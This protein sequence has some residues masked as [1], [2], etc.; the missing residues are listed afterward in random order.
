VRNLMWNDT[1]RY[2]RLF[3]DALMTGNRAGQTYFYHP[4]L[5]VNKS[6][7]GAWITYEKQAVAAHSCI[8]DRVNYSLEREGRTERIRNIPTSGALVALVERAINQGIPGM[9]TGTTAERLNQIFV[10]N[11]HP[12]DFAWYY[13]SLVSYASIY[14]RSPAELPYRPDSI[15]AAAM[16][17]LR[18][19]AWD[20]VRQYETG[21]VAKTPAQCADLMV[22]SFCAAFRTVTG[23]DPSGCRARF[24][25]TS[26]D[27]PFYY[28]AASDRSY[29][30][31]P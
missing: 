14:H 26:T 10:D 4:W 1:V 3:H 16:P 6:A 20:Y 18:T 19:L 25:Q 15:P 2:L 5:D 24:Q 8:A 28:D 12:T 9:S 7:P 21:Y 31:T 29:W 22:N 27:N 23:D 13:L 30:F 17:V 11:V